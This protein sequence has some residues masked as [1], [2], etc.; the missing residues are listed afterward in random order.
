MTMQNENPPQN[1]WIEGEFKD[2]FHHGD[3]TLIRWKAN[4]AW[5]SRFEV[6]F[7]SE[8]GKWY[9]SVDIDVNDDGLCVYSF[10]HGSGY[11]PDSPASVTIPWPIIVEIMRHRGLI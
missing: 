6:E 11:D 5:V 1:V 10:L 7:G 9:H 8:S 2:T 4:S 3:F